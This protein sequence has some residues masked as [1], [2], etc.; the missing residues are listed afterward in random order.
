VEGERWVE[1]E[2]LR[3][4]GRE[5]RFRQR[6]LEDD[7]ECV[8]TLLEAAELPKP[9]RAGAQVILEPGAPVVWFTFRGL[10]HDV[11]RFHLR[12]GTFTGFYA[13]VLTPVE[14]EGDRWRTT[15][16]CLDVWM[17][18]EGGVE[19]LDEDELAEAERHGWATAE[20]A[21]RARGEAAALVERARDGRWP[22]AR[23]HE[24]TLERARASIQS[25]TR[26]R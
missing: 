11:G 14:M 6:V 8:V 25:T 7:G 21:A 4:S 5:Q 24:W 19:L 13:N 16:L 26:V 3:L 18:A 20:T 17:D 10:W 12:D 15:D 1:I 22:P 2:Y 23:L 9:V